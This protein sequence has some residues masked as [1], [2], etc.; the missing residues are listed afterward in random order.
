MSKNV[1]AIDKK[2]HQACAISVHAWTGF[3]A[4][5]PRKLLVSRISRTPQNRLD[6][7]AVRAVRGIRFLPLAYKLLTTRPDS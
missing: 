7:H 4:S 2:T 3:L 1:F 5:G 6:A